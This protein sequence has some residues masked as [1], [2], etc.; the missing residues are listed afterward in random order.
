MM[1]MDQKREQ[2]YEID[3]GATSSEAFRTYLLSHQLSFL[4]VAN[5]SAL[6]QVSAYNIA[7]G[8][9]I[10]PEHEDAVRLGLWKLTG[11]PYTAFIYTLPK[12][13]LNHG[14]ER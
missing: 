7:N 4:Q 2:L 8:V 14:Q 11:E 12:S 13:P 6:H 3:L 9:P 10:L 5:A 1:A